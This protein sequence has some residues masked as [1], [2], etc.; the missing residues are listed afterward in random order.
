MTELDK[1]KKAIDIANN[2]IQQQ[3]KTVENIHARL[4]EIPKMLN[5]VSEVI[6]TINKERKQTEQSLDVL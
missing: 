5:P 1:T 6:E 4:T 3:E 2:L